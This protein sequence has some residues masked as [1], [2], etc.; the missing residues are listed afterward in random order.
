MKDTLEECVG[1]TIWWP[2]AQLKR[3]SRA[4]TVDATHVALVF[5]FLEHECENTCTPLMQPTV[6]GSSQPIGSSEH[7]SNQTPTHTMAI[8]FVDG[9]SSNSQ[10]R[11][12]IYQNREERRLYIRRR[13]KDRSSKVTL[14]TIREDLAQY[15]CQRRCLE[16][17]HELDICGLR[18]KAWDSKSYS[19]WGAWIRGILEAAKVCY[20]VEGRERVKFQLKIGDL[21]MCNKCYGVDVGYSKRHFKR[22]KG[23]VHAGCVVAIYGNSQRI[24]EGTHTSAARVVLEQ[25]IASAGC[26]QPHRDIKRLCDEHFVF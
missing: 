16:N 11:T 23:V 3:R 6:I 25:Y 20:I 1:C 2:Q 18:Y 19:E 12:Y 22:L 21:A 8:P 5:E 26:P 4:P 9:L 13:G 15:Q 17:I 14:V 10:Q 7:D 24:S